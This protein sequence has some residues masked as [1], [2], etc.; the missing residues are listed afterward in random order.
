MTSVSPYISS[1]DLNLVKH[2]IT[3]FNV[4]A[5]GFLLER[6]NSKRLQVYMEKVGEVD[7]DRPERQMCQVSK[8]TKYIWHTHPHNLWQYPSPEDIYTIMKWH[9]L[10]SESKT[11]DWPRTSV[12]F[13]GW[14]IWEISF[15]HVKFQLDKNWLRFLHELSDRE[16]H[17]IW[18]MTK[19]EK[20]LSKNIIAHIHGTIGTIVANINKQPWVNNVFK[21]SFTPW[22]NIRAGRSYFLK[23]S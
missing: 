8:Y 9:S 21:M 11:N 4:E 17:G 20:Q 6:K 19:D 13:S 12:M 7:K 5:C 3:D 10:N 15:P 1:D 14:G 18:Q 16:F 2:L 22:S 23:F